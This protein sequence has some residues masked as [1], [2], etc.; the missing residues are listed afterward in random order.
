MQNNCMD[1]IIRKKKILIWSIMVLFFGWSLYF[2]CQFYYNYQRL[3]YMEEQTQALQEVVFEWKND[4]NMYKKTQIGRR[5]ITYK[6]KS[7]QEQLVKIEAQVENIKVPSKHAS[8][9][10]NLIMLSNNISSS[11]KLTVMW[12]NKG[13]DV[14]GVKAKEYIDTAIELLK[15][16]K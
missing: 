13:D 2:L 14:L 12:L 1:F 3:Q 10:N 6:I 15:E 8:Q 4:I 5:Q 16:T 11:L 7:L 9:K